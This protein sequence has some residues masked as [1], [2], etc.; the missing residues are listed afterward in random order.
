MESDHPS[1]HRCPTDRHSNPREHTLTNLL[2]P[3]LPFSQSRHRQMTIPFRFCE[4]ENEPNLEQNSAAICLRSALT[5]INKSSFDNAR[6]VDDRSVC[7]RLP[8]ARGVVITLTIVQRMKSTRVSACQQAAT[9]LILNTQVRP[10]MTPITP[11]CKATRA[12]VS[13]QLIRIPDMNRINVT[14]RNVV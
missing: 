5:P 13:N 1:T 10:L 3:S 9:M 12:D 8:A 6:L 14:H 4:L 2:P 11:G 7:D